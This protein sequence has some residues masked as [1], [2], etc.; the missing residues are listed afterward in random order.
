[1]AVECELLLVPV[2]NVVL[3]ALSD[4]TLDLVITRAWGGETVTLGSHKIALG[5]TYRTRWTLF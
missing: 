5:I 2:G 1:M 4:I 3:G